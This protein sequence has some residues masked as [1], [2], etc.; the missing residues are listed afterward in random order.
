LGSFG[1]AHAHPLGNFTINRYSSL[2]AGDRELQVHYIV[3][4]AEI[5]AHSER[6]LIDRDG[7]GILAEGEL[8]PYRQ[9]KADELRRG[10]TLR[11]MGPGGA[12]ALP[13][14]VV[15][16]KLSFPRGQ[17]GLPTLRLEL[18]LLAQLP[19]AG[20]GQAAFQVEYSDMNYRDRLGWQEVVAA[21][22]P[23]AAIADSSVPEEDR[24][25]QLTQYPQELATEPPQVTTATFTWQPHASGR[26]SSEATAAPGT[27]TAA[28]LPIVARAGDPFA[29]LVAIPELGFGAVLLALLAAFGWGAMHAMSP[30]HGK[31]LVAAYLVGAHGTARHA[32]FLGLTT[33]ITHT[34][35]VFALGFVT[36][37]LSRY[38][39]PE[40]LYPWLSAASG[41]LVV[42]IGVSLARTRLRLG[43][44]SGAKHH[45]HSHDPDHDHSHDP[46]HG[47]D[48]GHEHSHGHDHGHGHSHGHDHSHDHG[49]H[50]GHGHSHLPPGADGR[51]VTWRSLLA[52]GVSGGLLPCPSAL[53]LMLAAISLNRIGFG[54]LLIVA[55]SL[56]L[57]GVLTVFGMALV[58]AGNWFT[59]IPEG[60]RV[61]RFVPAASAL[62]I[63]AAGLL[64]TLQALGQAGVI[65]PLPPLL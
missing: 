42:A 38:I 40:Q 58:H 13:L 30:G 6:A 29:D 54:L 9:R 62:F 49:H 45:D 31:T 48:H 64:I 28:A 34:A 37:A 18:Q 11:V 41:L 17:A 51:R 63:T 22:R 16:T 55:F 32:L 60:G 20:P 10:L 47:H 5:P 39:L 27:A 53:V 26:S 33:T 8:G 12:V 50:H 3:D 46:D 52:L 21:A 4:M 35:G 57:A 15:S 2:V 36:L 23:G 61:L 25:R 59:R 14:T 24:S 1:V 65:A 7:D 44:G 43:H 56:G 19:A